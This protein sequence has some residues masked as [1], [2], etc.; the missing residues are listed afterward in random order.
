MVL[1]LVE[2]DLGYLKAVLTNFNHLVHF[3]GTVALIVLIIQM[4]LEVIKVKPLTDF[5]DH[6]LPL[7]I[8]LLYFVMSRIYIR[9]AGHVAE[10]TAIM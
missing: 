2:H 8:S 3:D 9:K 5:Y 7:F 10:V 1:C 6:A 4:I